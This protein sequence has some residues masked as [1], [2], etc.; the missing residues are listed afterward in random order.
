VYEDGTA[1]KLFCAVFSLADFLYRIYEISTTGVATLVYTTGAPAVSD[2]AGSFSLRNGLIIPIEATPPAANL[3]PYYNG[4]SWQLSTLSYNSS[5]V[6]IGPNVYFKGRAFFM[7]GA[8]PGLLIY[9]DL[10]QVQGA[11]NI[12]YAFPVG[13]IFT[14]SKKIAWMGEFN[15]PGRSDDSSFFAIGNITGEVLI[16]SGDHPSADNWKLES[17][18]LTG[19]PISSTSATNNNWGNAATAFEDDLW[20]LTY[21]GVYSIRDVFTQGEKA[22]GIKSS[23]SADINP[24]WSSLTDQAKGHFSY[25]QNLPS[26]AFSKKDRRF[27]ILVRGGLAVDGTF[28]Y[29]GLN[30]ILVCNLDTNAW[31]IHQ[32]VSRPDIGGGPGLLTYWNN[33]LYYSSVRDIF[34]LSLTEFLDEYR[35]ASGNIVKIGYPVQIHGAPTTFTNVTAVKKLEGFAPIVKQ[36][37]PRFGFGV[38][39]STDFGRKES[40]SV[41][42]ANQEDFNKLFYSAGVE[43]TFFQYKLEG[44]TSTTTGIVTSSGGLELY[45]VNAFYKEGAIL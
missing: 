36:V 1:S 32:I 24:Y 13:Q 44:D 29:D 7:D 34:K 21:T 20:V 28:T 33:D 42:P 3:N 26:A 10:L 43:G 30:T 8:N 18:I 17:K 6:Q 22:A 35:D 4:S 15:I 5:R 12:L 27:Y 11:V 9:G 38:K 45:A 23:I 25:P 14:F 2:R 37:A 31:S 19:A 40:G 16:Y 41:S 39:A